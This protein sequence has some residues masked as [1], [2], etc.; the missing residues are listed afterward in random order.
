MANNQK[1]SPVQSPARLSSSVSYKIGGREYTAKDV[2][3]LQ[4]QM[5]EVHKTNSSDNAP[6]QVSKPLENQYGV[7]KTGV[8][9]TKTSGSFAPGSPPVAPAN[10]ESAKTTSPVRQ[11]SSYETVYRRGAT[12][13]KDSVLS[14][15]KTLVS[16]AQS[17]LTS[18]DDL[19]TKAV[20]GAIATGVA[21]VATFKA[22]QQASLIGVEGAKKV[23]SG[24][25]EIASTTGRGAVT[26]GRTVKT[27][28]DKQTVLFSKDTLNILKEQARISGFTDTKI[29]KTVVS[30]ADKLKQAGN[31]VVAGARKVKTAVDTSVKIVRGVKSG[32]LTVNMA[33]TALDAFRKRAFQGI[34]TGLKSGVKT[35]VKGAGKGLTTAVVKGVPGTA[36]I[37]NKGMMVA[38]GAMIASEDSAVQGV[39]YAAIATRVGVKTAVAGGK[40]ATK[41]A[42][43]TVKT[44]VKG[45]RVLF[46]GTKFIKNNG[47]RA[48]WQKA[49]VKAA[50]A[51]AKA[52]KSAVS[53]VL[54]LA[55]AV[56]MKFAIP[57]LLIVAVVLAASGG[58]TAPISAVASIFG[59]VFDTS[60]TNAEH[61][62]RDYLL[63]PGFGVPAL[64]GGFKQ[65]LADEM[66]DSKSDYHIVRF[67]SNSD[68]DGAISPTLEGI[69]SVFK[70]DEQ[71][72]SMLQPMFNAIILME[73]EL[74]PTEAQA[75]ALISELFNGL[76]R[77]TT[78]ETIEQCG[79]AIADGEG[80]V[81][82]HECGVIHALEDCP[83]PVTA[84]HPSYT[85]DECCIY[86]YTCDGH[87]GSLKCGNAEHTHVNWVSESVPGCYSTIK[88]EGELTTDCGNSTRHSRC[89]GYQYCDS[90]KVISY[91]LTLDGAYALEA[92]YFADPI[93]RLSNIPENQRT[94]AEQ[95][96][97]QN[98]KDYYEIYSELMMQVAQEYGSGM[99]M[100]DLSGVH[101]V[102]GTRIGNQ[103]VVDRA[104]SQ[105]GQQGGQPYWSYYGFGYRVEWCGC[106]VH[107]CMRTTPS[108]TAAWPTTANNAYC[109][110]IAEH[111]EA[112][113]QFGDKNFT[114]L[115]P[116]DVILF[117]W[118]P[119]GSAD[120]VGIV[121]GHD[122]TYVYTVEGNSGDAVKI[123]QYQIGSSVIYGYGLMNYQ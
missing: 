89:T 70:T 22:A 100:S 108:A 115:V 92:K 98:L 16:K 76:F 45:G 103:A 41:A 117:D 37:L 122:G 69:S 99:S 63:D 67:Y 118:E 30:N 44:A 121:I 88:H 79:Q 35:A 7:I 85:C 48:A 24:A 46:K 95:E 53:A 20:E 57:L 64:S 49:R 66:K 105:V 101:F 56:G 96:Q 110:T 119:D 54:H 93:N 2:S 8:G 36:R 17:G 102:N 62:V 28:I 58:L 123:K 42:G 29:V 12:T 97:L 15:G 38:A 116:G 26:V 114:N 91:T 87:K 80:T 6:R 60:D 32:T 94:E 14:D 106:F 19:G 82:P 81:T 27:V 50:Q 51:I 18:S 10:T 59:G 1:S 47:L 43:Y 120:H 71:L 33:K 112:A 13:P 107:W 113:G 104:L 111:F 78:S 25:V 90:H 52:G 5:K 31:A 77:V 4:A 83:N 68:S 3:R 109:P 9:E 86:T 74:S 23:G 40:A 55:K 72:A 84:Y 21:S 61:N 75:K 73:Y 11:G 34:K 39:G 65:S